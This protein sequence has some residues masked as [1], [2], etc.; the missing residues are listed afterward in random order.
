MVEQQQ[1]TD[2]PV[3]LRQLEAIGMLPYLIFT[4]FFQ[5]MQPIAVGQRE[6]NY[7]FLVLKIRQEASKSGAAFNNVKI[8]PDTGPTGCTASAKSVNGMRC[9]QI[10][11]FAIINDLHDDE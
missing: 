6:I 10:H 7:A 4:S 2:Q 3:D 8:Q 5:L 11:T 1:W 9:I